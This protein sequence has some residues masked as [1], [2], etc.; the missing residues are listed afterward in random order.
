MTGLVAL[1]RTIKLLRSSPI[2]PTLGSPFDDPILEAEMDSKALALLSPN[3][4]EIYFQAKEFSKVNQPLEGDFPWMNALVEEKGIQAY[5]FQSDAQS[6]IQL[7]ITAK[8]ELT[9]SLDSPSQSLDTPPTLSVQTNIPIPLKGRIS[10]DTFYMEF[11]IF[12]MD[13]SD[14]LISLG[15]TTLPYPSFVLPGRFPFSIGYDST[16]ARHFNMPFPKNPELKPLEQ[17]DTLGIGLRIFSRSVFFTLNGKKL[18]ES[19]FGGHFRLPKSVLLYPTIGVSLSQ[20]SSCRIDANLGQAGFVFIEANVKKWGLASLE[21]NQ[22]PPP[23]YERWNED[24]VLE[25]TD[26][27]GPPDFD[28]ILEL[29]G[30]ELAASLLTNEEGECVTLDTLPNYDHMVEE[31]IR[32]AMETGL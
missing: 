30:E 28:D 10:Q 3:Q 18:S 4:Q 12:A 19:K 7:Q 22:P 20:P 15:L 31:E 2:P 27:E 1:I 21:G 26:D 11:K 24:V 13:S 9:F 16:G 8:T 5:S 25:Y 32:Q 29:R 23:R 17:G 6:D 14:I